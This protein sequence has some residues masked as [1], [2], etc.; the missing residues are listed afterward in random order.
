VRGN[1][2]QRPAIAHQQPPLI[3]CAFVG[4]QGC[5]HSASS[6]LLGN[7]TQDVKHN[8]DDKN[9]TVLSRRRHKLDC[10]SGR[11]ALADG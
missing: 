10:T 11:I 6:V 9:F 7:K 4:D 3:V 2:W 5:I 8:E 1:H